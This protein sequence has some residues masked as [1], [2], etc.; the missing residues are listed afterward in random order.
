LV[1][2]LIVAVHLLLGI[3]LF[4]SSGPAA[5]PARLDSGTGGF[6][7]G[8]G[9]AAAALPAPEPK[10]FTLSFDRTP[11]I[12]PSTYAPPTRPARATRKVAP[13]PHPS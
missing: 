6:A 11:L 3:L 7:G 4:S 1:L 13:S 10:R 12:G 2:G 5:G 9:L 8:T